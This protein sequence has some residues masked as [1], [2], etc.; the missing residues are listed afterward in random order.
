LAFAMPNQ[1]LGTIVGQPQSSISITGCT[2]GTS[3]SCTATG[4]N[5]GNG[6]NGGAGIGIGGVAVSGQNDPLGMQ[7]QQQGAT[8]NHNTGIGQGGPGGNGGSGGTACN[9]GICTGAHTTNILSPFGPTNL[10]LQRSHR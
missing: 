8:A 10:Q 3:T 6:G 9:V 5:G 1:A 2:G 7:R 4:G